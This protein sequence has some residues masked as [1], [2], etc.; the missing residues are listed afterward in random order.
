ML[1]FTAV[2][3]RTKARMSPYF[4][5]RTVISVSLSPIFWVLMTRPSVSIFTAP[6]L[7]LLTLNYIEKAC[8]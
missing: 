2:E 7:L 5:V 1:L 6:H 8:G 3:R 4:D